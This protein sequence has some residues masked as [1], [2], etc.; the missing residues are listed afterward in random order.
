MNYGR[1]YILCDMTCRIIE[2]CSEKTWYLATDRHTYTHA[3]SHSVRTS[4]R[5]VTTKRKIRI[6]D[7]PKFTSIVS[8][9]ST[10]DQ[11][12]NIEHARCT[13]I[14][15]L[16]P[17]RCLPLRNEVKSFLRKMIAIVV[18]V[19]PLPNRLQSPHIFASHSMPIMFTHSS[20]VCTHTRAAHTYFA[21]GSLENFD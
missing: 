10:P 1:I 5:I 17:K 9:L 3:P 15:E 12:K 8:I 11:C 14:S 6:H 2:N 13:L 18:I 20:A 4:L 19:I 16:R 7:C 21:H